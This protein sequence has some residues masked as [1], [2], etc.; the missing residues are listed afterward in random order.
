MY[1]YF[2]AFNIQYAWLGVHLLRSVHVNSPNS[3][4]KVFL[5]LSPKDVGSKTVN[6]LVKIISLSNPN[7]E[8]LIVVDEKDR[9]SEELARL[10]AG[11]RTFLF[12][13]KRKETFDD[14]V[15]AVWIDADSI[16]RGDLSELEA[17]CEKNDFD[18]S[19]RA[20]NTKFKFAS[21]L[22]IQKGTQAGKDFGQKWHEHTP[23]GLENTTGHYAQMEAM[24]LKKLKYADEMGT[25]RQL[26]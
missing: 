8:V 9:D 4:F 14:N 11:Y 10:C 6:E 17:F 12:G 2:T 1:V 21:G 5:I 18:I 23:A 3:N 25:R 26:L 20:K 19:A 15:T 13:P 7:A 16:V 24:Y 22:V